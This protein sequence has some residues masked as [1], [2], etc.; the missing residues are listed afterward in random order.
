[1]QADFICLA[2]KRL[3]IA[4]K[5]S[6]AADI[7]KAL[8][9]FTKNA[10]G[11]FERTDMIITN[12]LGHLVA[13]DVPEAK[14]AARG[15][16]GL[17]VITDKFALV[18]TEKGLSQLKVIK[19]LVARS[20]VTEIINAC[21]AGREGELI[22]GLI[23][24]YL[25]CTKPVLRM[26]AQTMTPEGLR[27]AY[28]FA[29]SGSE[30]AG[31]YAAAK[32]RTEADWLVGINGSRGCKELRSKEVG[33][34]EAMNVGR[35]QTPTLAL[36]VRREREILT[37]VS[38]PYWEI[39]A[40]FGAA[41]GAYKG[42]LHNPNF[43]QTGVEDEASKTK[44]FDKA[45]ADALLQRL[46]GK[47]VACV[48]EEVSESLRKPPFLFD[49]TSLQRECNSRF[50]FSAKK[51]LDIAQ[52]LYEKHKMTT[53][54][55]TDSNALPEDYP[56]T[57]KKTLGRFKA[58]PWGAHVSA[59]LDNDWV[60]PA[61]KR[62]FNNDKISDHFAII[63]TGEIS[64]SVTDDERKVFS[65]ITERFLAAFFP[66]ARLQKTARVTVIDGVEF[67]SSGTVVVE[68]GWMRVVR[69][70]DESGA[71][72][73]VGEELCALDAGETPKVTSLDQT[74]S[75]TAP[76]GRFTEASL[77][78][79]ME[80]AG[81][82]IDDDELRSIMKEKG[83]GTPAT[84]AAIIE[85]LCDDGTQSGRPKE[86]YLRR[87]KNHLVPTPKAMQLIEFLELNGAAFLTSAS[88]TGEWEFKLGQME[89]G[90]YE[91]PR[92]MGEI[93][94]TVRDLIEIL[95]TQAG[96]VVTKSTPLGVKCPKCKTAGAV[97]TQA[98]YQCE[99]LDVS[100]DFRVPK[101]I[102]KRPMSEKEMADIFSGKVVGPLTGFKKKSG[103]GSFEAFL[104][105]NGEGLEF[106]F[107]G[108]EGA[109][110]EKLKSSCP[111]CDSALIKKSW[112][113]ACE[114]CEFTFKRSMAGRMF[115]DAELDTLVTK[116]ELP[117]L[118][119]FKKAD[120]SSFSAGVKLSLG[121]GSLSFCFET[122]F[123]APCP[124]CG[125]KVLSKG[126]KFECSSCGM[127]GWK[128]MSGR[129]FKNSEI[130]Q[131]LKTGKLGTVNGFVSNST[132]KVFAAGVIG[133]VEGKDFKFN[134]D[135][136]NSKPRARS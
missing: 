1:M 10:D 104:K 119:G 123:S 84:R 65:L 8:G 122:A 80:A 23:M 46:Q 64:A 18:P 113:I 111:K 44:F 24:E 109:P 131:L 89:K 37:F 118:S 47:P 102:A 22:F 86:P 129:E 35:V 50:K 49:L 27:E 76:P 32:C 56:D 69:E 31:L 105:W 103:Q 12:A 51:T 116:G 112:D 60:N 42:K 72:K 134:F 14:N 135:F 25:E 126:K 17:P 92:F 70:V 55:R 130:E 125:G 4:E 57:V 39:S 40:T 63:P 30:R 91:R 77:L 82:Q 83:L 9:G 98:S 107:P 120:K 58:S 45:S 5:P 114:T 13:V 110:V 124:A 19:S 115:S 67:H 3:L 43:G 33:G 85:N 62:V 75:K 100:C 94:Q 71:V 29:R 106:V 81:K 48:S 87:E 20:D 26:W 90:M 21:D 121:D 128:T 132:K 101:L 127:S 73:G 11:S 28:T 117:E 78:A 52:R 79:A 96:K 41:A 34:S 7:A 88:M 97:V 38:K 68:P 66:D 16:A 53:Y 136:S 108:S 59:I 61:N 74:E 99:A 6:V 133:K 15:F 2:M 93:H 95:R 54:P 36:V